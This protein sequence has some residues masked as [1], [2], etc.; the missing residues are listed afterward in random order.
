MLTPTEDYMKPIREDFSNLMI[1][2]REMYNL[3]LSQEYIIELKKIHKILWILIIWKK[4]LKN[5][6]YYND[7]I[8]NILSLIHVSVHKDINIM[9]FLLRKSIEDFLRFM[10]IYVPNIRSISKVSDVFE[11]IFEYSIN[12]K[13]LHNNWEIIKSIYSGCCLTVHSNGV[14]E[15]QDLCTCLK[16][17]D[18]YY[19]DKDMQENASAWAKTINHFC[20][21]LILND[22]NLFKRIPLNDQ[23]IIRDFLSRDNL[24]EISKRLD[25]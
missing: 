22:I 16:N 5:S 18:E 9:N 19:C 4:Y 6:N 3:E 20:N 11:T 23:A 10:E 13:Y 25:I 21:I 24:R 7:I 8:L 12:D 2:L 15:T 1:Y 17:Y 14:I